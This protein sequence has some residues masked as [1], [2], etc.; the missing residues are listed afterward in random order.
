MN[1]EIQKLK[2]NFGK[3]QA[4]YIDQLLVRDCQTLVFMGPSG[5]GKSTLLKLIAG[6]YCPDS[7]TI[8]VDG[9]KIIYEEK[10]LLKYRRKIGVVF[11]SWNLFPHL[12]ALENIVLPLQQVHG[13][14]EEEATAI[15]IKLLKQFELDKH[16]DK[17]PYALSG[18][19]VQRV[20]LIRAIAI[21]PKL[22]LLD[23]PTSALDP[24]M[25]SEVLDLILELK[26]EKRNLILVTHHLQFAKRIADRVIF[27]SEGRVLENGTTDQVFENPLS[28]QAKNY[29]SKV[30]TY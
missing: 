5:G 30:L 10:D 28:L 19:Q 26:N 8:A 11:Q 25:T 3:Q 9:Q 24:L 21:Q 16:A 29:M 13:H 17:K 20:A 18:G 7:G 27:I 22:L 15:G 14:S 1:L 4:I 2:K 6:L 12:T 23:E